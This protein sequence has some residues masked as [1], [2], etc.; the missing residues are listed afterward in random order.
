MCDHDLDLFCFLLSFLV[1][2]QHIYFRL[3]FVKLIKY[4]VLSTLCLAWA[5]PVLPV[6]DLNHFKLQHLPLF[7]FTE[8]QIL[9][10]KSKRKMEVGNKNN[11][12]DILEVM[13]IWKGARSSKQKASLLFFLYRR[14]KGSLVR[15]CVRQQQVWCVHCLLS[16]LALQQRQNRTSSALSIVFI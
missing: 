12:T 1:N 14:T 10:N 8:L 16:Q 6:W 2:T 9:H 15:P 7:H 5:L 3:R 13:K 11:H 4:F